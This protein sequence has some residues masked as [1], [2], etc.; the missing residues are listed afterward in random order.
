MDAV[1]D[2]AMACASKSSAKGRV[3]V[4]LK[5]GG[6][7]HVASVTVEASPDDALGACVKATVSR[8]TFPQTNTGGSFSVPYTF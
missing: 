7:G 6:D 1:R 5:V 4:H 8:A 3:K 2:R